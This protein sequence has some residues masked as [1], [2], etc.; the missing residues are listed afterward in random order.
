MPWRIAVF[1]P[2]TSPRAFSNGPPE[3]PGLIAA[4]VWMK[5]TRLSGSPV[6]ALLERPV[7]LMIPVVTVLSNPRGLPIA[8]AHS[9]GLSRSELPKATA[10]KL[11]ASILTT[12]TSVTGS[13]PKTLPWYLRPSLSITDTVSAPSTT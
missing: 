7:A 4:S 8:I 1:I 13:L 10:G 6:I 9:P 3:L 5:L 2:I 11:F 12:A